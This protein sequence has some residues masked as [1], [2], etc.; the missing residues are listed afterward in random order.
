[1]KFISWILARPHTILALLALVILDGIL[2]FNAMPLNLFPDSNRPTISVVTSWPGAAAK[3]VATEVTHPIEVGL[4]AIDGVRR[5]TSTSRDEVSA[6]QVEFEYGIDISTAATNVTTELPRVTGQL[7]DG[8]R[9]PLIFKITEAARPAVV[10]AATAAKGFDL[11]LGQI[12][13]LVENPVRDELLNIPGVAEVEVFGG[14]KRQ[15][16]ID[17]DRNKLEA[18]AISPDA[19]ARALEGS[20][21]SKPAGLVHRHG[22][23]LLLTAKA[24][25]RLPEDL[26][27]VLV[28]LPG[29]THVRVGD[30]GTVGW[31]AA[32]PTS[33]Y[34]GN[35]K[36][37]VAISLLRGDNGD[38]SV[39]IATIEKFLP[40]LTKDYPMLS[41]S[42]A[43]TQGR[44]I[45]QTVGNMLE[46]L[47]EAVLMTLIVILLFLNNS[48]AA[49]ITALSIPLTYL[50]TFVVL[51]LMGYEFD[52][53]T[54]TAIVI[55]VG[56]LADDAVVVIENIERRMRAGTESAMSAAVK[57]TG[58]ILL[59][60]TSGTI[61]TIAVLLPIMFIGGFV[62]TILRPLTVTLSVALAASLVISVTIIPLLVPMI[63]K[64]GKS[65]PLAFI[66]R[67]FDRF[68]IVPVRHFFV[69]TTRRALEH[70][71]PVA[72]AFLI[73][74]VVSA[75]QIPFLGREIMPLMDTGVMIVSF[76]A[77]PNTDADAMQEIAT[78]IDKAVR[79][80]MDEDWFLSSS[81]IIGAEP[82][83]KS[84]GAA[85]TLQTGSLTVNI[86][87]RFERNQSIYEIEHNIRQ[88]VRHIPGL[89]S[90]NVSEFGATALSSIRGA[91]DIM[92]T[93]PDPLILDQLGD[94]VMTRLSTV[95][96]LT[97]V[98]RTWQGEAQQLNLNVSPVLARLYGLT[99]K[100]VAQ[101]V[102]IAVQGI[103]G[104]RLRID[105][106]NSLPV[107][108]R[109]QASQRSSQEALEALPIRTVS[110]KFIPLAALASPTLSFAP[111][112]QTHQA[113]LPTLDVVG[114]R[115]NI[116]LTRL[117]AHV[118]EALSGLPLPRGYT[119]SYEGEYKQ[120]G[121]S[122][123][124]LRNA[125]IIGLGLLFLMLIITF[126]SF[127]DPIAIMASLP[128]SVI[129]A[130]W[131]MMLADKHGSMPSFMGFI[132]LM[133][134]AVN[135]G[136]LLI[137]FTK[138]ALK[139]GKPLKEALIQSVELRT[140]PILMTAFASSVGMLPI[141]MEWSVGIERLSPLAVVAI[142]GLMVGTFL[143][144]IAV[145]VFYFLLHR[146][147]A[148]F[149]A[150]FDEK[151][152]KAAE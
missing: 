123:T 24:L 11:D 32:D 148:K 66:L 19:V 47:R 103:P 20:N 105:G 92:I 82:G 121:E 56:L 139:A 76:E 23:R 144:L 113:L 45:H 98:E 17:L 101:Q 40:Q 29:G 116:S 91:V 112:A 94:D 65:D 111:T 5:V 127:L 70:P 28:P 73:L 90:S 37:A 150:F 44:L 93:G 77:Q 138:E 7:P 71:V 18:F 21:I 114:Y 52:M 58:E 53:I 34:H 96:G 68:F 126:G 140:R 80:S 6:V 136:I 9:S 142:G 69:R 83:V 1:V 100:D 151:Q 26:A 27:E 64:P 87:N 35:G 55:A 48:R 143:T 59:A 62:Q 72:F 152:S 110:G 75:P 51:H 132:L 33:I 129:G 119:I 36:A 63:M 8:T 38:A 149:I 86:V 104:G 31:G 54:L 74:F 85:R 107:W 10:L 134:I 141:A 14:D 78:R 137:D 39:V 115:R 147:R 2:S 128:L 25:A 99:A 145:P 41:L 4:S 130:V 146:G 124:R 43:D 60:D 61:T 125:L 12:R 50:L 13:R 81:M 131:A 108:V 49:F 117:H 106:E 89:V 95:K 97:G 16:S 3:D 120:M 57:G 102:A 67:P 42:V 15:I 84:F 135:N 133:G 46:S 118:S 109:L 79:A 88:R 122:F 30:L 22:F